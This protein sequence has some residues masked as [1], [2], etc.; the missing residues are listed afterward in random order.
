MLSSNKGSCLSRMVVTEQVHWDTSDSVPEEVRELRILVC[1]WVFKGKCGWDDQA[2]RVTW[3]QRG[4]TQVSRRFC[5]RANQR[6]EHNHKNNL[7]VVTIGPEQCGPEQR[8]DQD[9]IPAGWGADEGQVSLSAAAD[10]AATPTVHS[11]RHM[12]TGKEQV[13]EKR[14]GRQKTGEK[15]KT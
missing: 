6:H 12:Q 7:S 3:R 5:R 10:T 15:H 13:R 1:S 14:G 2:G 11:H 9:H 4:G 8:R